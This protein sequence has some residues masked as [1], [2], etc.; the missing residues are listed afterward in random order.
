[1]GSS[2]TVRSFGALGSSLSVFGVT[3]FGSAVS[4]LDWLHLGSS[5]SVRSYARCGSAFSVFGQA[6]VRELIFTARLVGADEASSIGLVTE[7]SDD[8]LA[9]AYGRR[10]VF[11]VEKRQLS[12]RDLR[13]LPGRPRARPARRR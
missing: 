13:D 9:R 11:A 6:R 12:K 1:M 3:K 2:L 8:P 10:G 4:V 7:I 5:L